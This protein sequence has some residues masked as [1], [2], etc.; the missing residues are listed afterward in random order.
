MD[1]P[2]A[3]DDPNAVQGLVSWVFGTNVPADRTILVDADNAGVKLTYGELQTAVRQAISGLDHEGVAHGDIV[4]VVAFNSVFYYALVLAIIG[5][6][7]IFVG[8]NPGHTAAEIAA[9]MGLAKPKMVFA[10]PEL[11]ARTAAAANKAGD[12]TKLVIFDHSANNNAGDNHKTWKDIIAIG[13]EQPWRTIPEPSTTIAQYASTSGTSG[14]PKLAL[15]PHA[16]HVDQARALHERTTHYP[17]RRL[18][19]LPPFHTFATPIVP[20]SIR[21]G[22]PV[23]IMKRFDLTRFVAHVQR[24][25]ITE[26]YLAPP[27]VGAVG[28]LARDRKDGCLHALRQVWWGGA[29][30]AQRDLLVLRQALHRDAIVQPVWG[31][32]EAGWIAA[33]AWP[34]RHDDDD[35]SVGRLLPGFQVRVVDGEGVHVPEGG[36]GELLVRCASPMLGY[37]DEPSATQQAFAPDGWLRTGDAGRVGGGKVWVVDRIKDM[38]KVR[39]WQVSP[40]EIEGVLLKHPHVVDAAVVSMV[41]DGEESPRA[42]IVPSEIIP[43]KELR[44]LLSTWLAGYKMPKVIQKVERIPRTLTGKIQRRVLQEYAI[45]T[46]SP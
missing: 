25:G 18:L 5:V 29:P 22:A 6:G 40:V 30:C 13:A 20:A 4:M 3:G 1:H 46:Y 42:F 10:E 7:G 15:I 37:L 2:L 19:C 14:P 35:G 8:V 38:M 26:T 27:C 9:Q 17:P 11:L 12:K 24:Y 34:E 32:T 33:G 16:Y 36:V 44:S 21:S 43:E 41:V 31:M 23:W 39:G 45:G 28:R